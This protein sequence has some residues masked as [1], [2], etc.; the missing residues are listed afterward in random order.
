MVHKSG[1]TIEIRQKGTLKVDDLAT[2]VKAKTSSVS[3]RYMQYVMN[4]LGD[5]GVSDNFRQSSNVVGA[6]VRG[7]EADGIEL[8]LPV[9][10]EKK[11]TVY[12]DQ[13]WLRWIPEDGKDSLFRGHT[14]VV[15]I[16]NLSGEELFVYE[17]RESFAEIDLAG[18]EDSEEL[19][20]LRVVTKEEGG[21]GLY[22]V[23][24]GVAKSDLTAKSEAL[25]NDLTSLQDELDLSIAV[26]RLLLAAFYEEN[27]MILEA[28]IQYERLIL[29]HP[30]V[31]DYLAFYQEFLSKNNML[32]IPQGK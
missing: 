8:L 21:D 3:G 10:E 5:D 31:D 12:G 2:K 7:T 25:Q 19:L 6:T 24:Y 28:M 9:V 29:E 16:T 15:T 1:K 27:G 22:S 20:L 23:Q 4:R 17:T 26:N 14:F 32:N 30:G 18:I 11:I 13:L